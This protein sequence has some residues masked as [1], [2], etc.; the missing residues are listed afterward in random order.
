M[1]EEVVMSFLSVQG[2]SGISVVY[3][4]TWY[5]FKTDIRFFFLFLVVRARIDIIKVSESFVLSISHIQ[6]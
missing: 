4:I 2:L 3:N 5:M 1:E 6:F